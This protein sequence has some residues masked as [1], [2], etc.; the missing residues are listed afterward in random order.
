MILGKTKNFLFGDFF[1]Q[2]SSPVM[3]GV[4]PRQ[5]CASR[6][7]NIAGLGLQRVRSRSGQTTCGSTPV[8][9]GTQ[10]WSHIWDMS[11]VYSSSDH[12]YD[13]D[14]QTDKKTVTPYTYAD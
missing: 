8:E 3:P 11:T 2:A 10:H 4:I 6:D 12:C 1:K 13:P 14:T 7:A 5:W 9:A